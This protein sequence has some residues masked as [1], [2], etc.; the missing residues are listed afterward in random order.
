MVRG[1][2]LNRC[3]NGCCSFSRYLDEY[4]AIGLGLSTVDLLLPWRC[5]A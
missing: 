5:F 4:I 1:G 2:C 3:L